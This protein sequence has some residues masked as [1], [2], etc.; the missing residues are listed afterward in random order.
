MAFKPRAQFDATRLRE[1]ARQA[2]E[3]NSIQDVELLCEYQDNLPGKVTAQTKVDFEWRL[4]FLGFEDRQT[5]NVRVNAAA[6]QGI[7]LPDSWRTAT[8]CLKL[9][10]IAAR[11]AAEAKTKLGLTNLSCAVLGQPKAAS[12]PAM[13]SALVPGVAVTLQ[14]ATGERFD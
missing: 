7:P 1:L 10:E 2:T 4:K 13:G 5:V 9:D 12:L 6:K 3:S 11:S 8:Q 14:G